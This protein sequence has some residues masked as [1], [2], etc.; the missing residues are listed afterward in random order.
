MMER[1]P[2]LPACDAVCGETGTRVYLDGLAL[3]SAWAARFEHVCGPLDREME[4]TRTT[5]NALIYTTNY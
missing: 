1:L 2:L 3:D 4:P 5:K